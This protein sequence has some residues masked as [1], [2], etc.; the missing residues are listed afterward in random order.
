MEKVTMN[1]ANC[2]KSSTWHQLDGEGPSGT[3]SYEIGKSYEF[4]II[5]NDLWGDSYKVKS[6]DGRIAG[7]GTNARAAYNFFKYFTL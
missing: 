1:R 7:F 2:I 6:D 4:E 5:E 3:F